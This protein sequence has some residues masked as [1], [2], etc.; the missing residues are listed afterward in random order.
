MKYVENL[1]YWASEV[2]NEFCNDS[3]KIESRVDITTGITTVYDL[4]T[5][6]SAFSKCKKSEEF[7]E[8]IGV[9]VAYTRLKG[10]E[11]PR[12]LQKTLLK[13]LVAGDEFALSELPKRTYYVVGINPL[14]PTEIIVVNK[15]DGDISR[16]KEHYEIYKI[17]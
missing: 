15:E 2:Y 9:A 3:E 17:I 7:S 11:V 12:V 5:G 10:G 16:F 14:K 4:R 13:N 6:E 1:C 8:E